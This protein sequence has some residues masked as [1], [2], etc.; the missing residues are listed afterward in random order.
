[1][2]PQDYTPITLVACTLAD[3]VQTLYD[4]ALDTHGEMPNLPER[5]RRETVTN[6]S[7]RFGLRSSTSNMYVTPRRDGCVPSL[8]SERSGTQHGPAAWNSLPV[9]IRAEIN[10]INFK[11][12][13]KTHFFN[14]A[15]FSLLC[16]LFFLFIVRTVNAVKLSQ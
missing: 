12:L 5:H 11:K 3:S 7:S 10:Q 8:E 4:D 9:N 2:S 6:S 13:L 15:F 1:M 16:I 14:L